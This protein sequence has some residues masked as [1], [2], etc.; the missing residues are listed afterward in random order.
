MRFVAFALIVVAAILLVASATYAAPQQEQKN[1]LDICNTCQF[2][3]TYLENIVNSTEKQI[4]QEAQLLCQMVP[5]QFKMICSSAVL[6]YLPIL[7]KKIETKDPKEACCWLS[8][9]V[10]PFCDSNTC[11]A[12]K[13]KKMIFGMANPFAGQQQ[14]KNNKAIDGCATCKLAVSVAENYLR[15]TT[16]R[17]EVKQM[18]EKQ[19][20]S[21]LPPQYQPICTMAVETYFDVAL[22][23]LLNNYNPDK[24]CSL[25][26]LCGNK[27]FVAPAFVASQKAAAAVVGDNG[28]ACNVCQGAISVVDGY[29]KNNETRQ[30][31]KNFILY[32]GCQA[33]P[34]NYVTLCSAIVQTNFDQVIDTLLSKFNPEKV[35]Q[36]IKI[37]PKQSMISFQQKGGLCSVC[38]VAVMYAESLLLSKKDDI[39]QFLKSNVCQRIPV[40]VAAATCS[41][42]VDT[43]YEQ[44]VNNLLAKYNP[45][46]VCDAIGCPAK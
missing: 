45:T 36:Q 21:L 35:C 6:M 37:C 1:Q 17:A 31:I 15:N 16:L 11:A 19:A 3:V 38:P 4:E 13:N 29:L 8:T 32:E 5:D 10:Y 39:Q 34:A 42:I 26:G 25:V 2:V 18:I 33:L 41:T 20:C 12:K 24:L 22:D 28:V 46:V 7:L 44:I 23:N 40:P 43:Q 9:K 30:A 14:K 27:T